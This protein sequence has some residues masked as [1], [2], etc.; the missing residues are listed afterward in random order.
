MLNKKTGKFHWL[1]LFYHQLLR[2]LCCHWY[3]E[4]GGMTGNFMLIVL[5][6][7]VSIIYPLA[8]LMRII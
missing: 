3:Q 8:E 4:R 1:L 6:K 5:R 7:Y 2:M